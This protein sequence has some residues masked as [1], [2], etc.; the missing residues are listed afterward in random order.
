MEGNKRCWQHRGMRAGS[1][2]SGLGSGITFLSCGVTLQNG[3]TCMRTPAY[4]R[5]RCEQHKGRRV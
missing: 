5:K 2:F 1:S 4:G 3:S